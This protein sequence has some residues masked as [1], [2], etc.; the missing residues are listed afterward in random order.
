MGAL[1]LPVT[2]T[3]TLNTARGQS[4]YGPWGMF[5]PGEP[6]HSHLRGEDLTLE[7]DPVPSREIV[8]ACLAM[9]LTAPRLT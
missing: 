3:D 2:S 7:T 5:A 9:S 4:V 1:G 8:G 6:A